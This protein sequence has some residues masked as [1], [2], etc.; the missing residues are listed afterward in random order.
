MK[1]EHLSSGIFKPGRHLEIYENEGHDPYQSHGK[2]ADPSACP[3][4]SAVYNAGQWQWISVPSHAQH[5]KCPACRRI[6]DK[7]PAGYVAIAGEF[8]QTHFDELMNLIQTMA[9]NEKAEHPMQRLMSIENQD[10][11]ALITTTSIRLAR[12]IGE[13]L[14]KAYKGQLDFKYNEAEHLLRVRWER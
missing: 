9:T 5:T 6:H 3:D 12:H 11:G 14:H 2:L 13:A 7:I 8:V 1:T 10:T 4:C